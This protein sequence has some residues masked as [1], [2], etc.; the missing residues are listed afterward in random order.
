MGGFTPPLSA[1][2]D[3]PRNLA[4]PVLTRL[5]NESAPPNPNRCPSSGRATERKSDWP[6]SGPVTV[7]KFQLVPWS[8]EIDPPHGPKSVWE[9]AGPSA[10]AWPRADTVFS[11][12][13]EP[14]A[15]NPPGPPRPSSLPP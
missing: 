10:P 12:A 1:V 15:P 3:D 6:G 9:A 4:V 11:Q 7:L 13:E 14:D 5:S 2:D 8:N